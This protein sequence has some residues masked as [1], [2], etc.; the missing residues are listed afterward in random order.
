MAIKGERCVACGSCVPVCEMGLTGRVDLSPADNRPGESCDRCGRC[1]TVCPSGARE[2]LGHDVT[3][4]ELMKEILR[5]L[6]YYQA[7]GGGVTFSG[8]EPLA[9]A[10][11]PFLLDI[12][13]ACGAA[14]LHRAVDTCGHAPVEKVMAVADKADL[15]LYDLK[16]VD[17]NRHRAAVGVDNDQIL[18]NL[19]AISAA[20]CEIWIRIPLIPGLTD[21]DE[22]LDASAEFITSLS[23]VHP[24]HL[25][26]YHHIAIEKYDR[27]G[28]DYDLEGMKPLTDAQVERAACRLRARGLS[29]MVGG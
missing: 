15:L 22:N 8:G 10:H 25:L 17:S 14:G 6:P 26:P 28:I 1:G 2:L 20:G 7:S 18:K 12:L 19:A 27:I 9:P 16:L 3:V 5:D 11:L 21:D 23:S 4:P 13:D 29:V 24:V